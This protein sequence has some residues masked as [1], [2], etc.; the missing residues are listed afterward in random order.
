MSKI[1]YNILTCLLLIGCSQND[2]ETSCYNIKD[3]QG[4]WRDTIF[5]GK[6]VYVEDL[7]INDN[8]VKYTLSDVNTHVVLDTLSGIILLGSENKIGWNCVS[9]ITNDNRQIYWNVLSLSA[10]QMKLYSNLQGEHNY[11]RVYRPSI[12][13][14]EIQ[15]TLMEMLQYKK[16]LPLHKDEL[17]KTFGLSNK[18][19]NDNEIVY[20]TCH[21]LFS[22]ISF[23][24]N[25]DNDSIYSYALSVKDWIKCYPFVTSSYTKL[26]N[27]GSTT[28]YIDGESLET[29]NNIVVA[30][31][32]SKQIKFMPI[33]DYDCWPNVSNYIGRHLQIFMND[34]GTKYVYEYQED[35]N[36]GLRAYK[37]LTSI[38]SICSN[39]FVV[40]DS[41]D[42]IRRSGVSM[43]K[44]FTS[45][46]K[47]DA[48]KELDRY[49]SFLN[50]KYFLN[51]T[52]LDENGNRNYYYY[53]SKDANEATYE[54]R[55]M[56][57]QY[58]LNNLTKTYQV[59]V[60]YV[61]L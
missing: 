6:D 50:R 30:D 55:L 56:L 58:D 25:N 31:F 13:E 17:V 11:R 10:Y 35:T 2:E 9:P 32:S 19:S 51:K 18:F 60:Y 23:K 21:P 24:K 49:A 20:F 61:Q 4:V 26:R 29:S 44:S 53:P 14:F 27:S 22:Q 8:S 28:E 33:K 15:D 47:K 57:V 40:V 37:F 3:Y 52:T 48:Q 59:R 45:N 5:N 46:K 38:D 1:F 7:I 36:S 39:I 12:E 54:I 42:I 16:H 34:F 41:T 43:L